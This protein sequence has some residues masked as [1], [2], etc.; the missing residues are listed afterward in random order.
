MNFPLVVGKRPLNVVMTVESD[1]PVVTLQGHPL[2]SAT[3]VRTFTGT[4]AGSVWTLH[5][6]LVPTDPVGLWELTA[7]ATANGETATVTRTTFVLAAGRFTAFRVRPTVV[8][9]GKQIYFS[10]RVQHTVNGRWKWLE[11][12]DVHIF[13]SAERPKPDSV[14][15]EVAHTP[16][17]SHGR[18]AT[19]V[20]TD[21]S[22]WY[23]ANFFEGDSNKGVW[24]GFSKTHAV[25]VK[26]VKARWD[27]WKHAK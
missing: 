2:G 18:F 13:Y 23:W 21:A 19:S 12:A 15:T 26:V 4:Q 24:V 16:S 17:D 5:T 6:T 8:R 25:R 1:A 7:T 27:A 20:T 3:P 14:G 22:G 11:N 10:G 9:K